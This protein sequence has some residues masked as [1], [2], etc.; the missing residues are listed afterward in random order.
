[1]KNLRI[2]KTIII[3]LIVLNVSTISYF[4]WNSQQARHRHRIPLS[5]VL[6]LSGKAAEE[7]TKLES[8]HF[9]AKDKLME[10]NRSLHLDLFDA[11]L[12]E[13]GTD[14]IKNALI[15]SNQIKDQL[16]CSSKV[17]FCFSISV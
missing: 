2:Y 16:F 8:E 14:S 4:I 12:E 11:F 13:N 3:L 15:D 1:M 6:Q 7:I 10:K 17:L 5:K 9:D